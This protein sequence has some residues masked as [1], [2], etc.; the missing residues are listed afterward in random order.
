MELPKLLQSAIEVQQLLRAECFRFCI[1]GGIAVQRWGEPRGTRDV[2]LTLLTGFGNESKHID[3]LLHKLE[4]RIPNAAEFAL[5]NRVLLVRDH[6]GVD[7][8]ISLGAMPFEERTVERASEYLFAENCALVT[9]SATDLIVH[10]AFASRDQDW[11]DIRGVL[12]RSRS[13]VD[14]QT[15]LRELMPL[16]E[17]K[18]EPEILDR[19]HELY[20]S[21]AE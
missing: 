2:D 11:I 5:L 16:V 3:V 10:K 19:L 8:D 9:C 18:E 15:V 6:R 14:W 1:I 13:V 4:P 12:T 17:L 21:T 20:Q 7:F